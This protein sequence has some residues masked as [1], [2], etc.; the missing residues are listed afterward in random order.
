[1][2][3]PGEPL[4]PPPKGGWAEGGWPSLGTEQPPSFRDTNVTLSPVWASK[5]LRLPAWDTAYVMGMVSKGTRL[6]C[7]HPSLALCLSFQHPYPTE[8][9]KRQIA[10]Q[11]NLTLLQVNNW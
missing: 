5:P 2:P 1:M 11:T 6:P 4:G 9:E 8:D 7:A 3:A 10:A